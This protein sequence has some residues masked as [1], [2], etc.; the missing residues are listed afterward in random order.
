MLIKKGVVKNESTILSIATVQNQKKN[1]TYS[2]IKDAD[3]AR[4]LQANMGYINENKMIKMIKLNQIS[5]C[6]VTEADIINS[7]NI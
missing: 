7:V 5:N 6:D 1:H 4:K 3:K 2:Q